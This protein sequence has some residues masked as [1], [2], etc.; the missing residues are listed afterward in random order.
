ME[1]PKNSVSAINAAKILGVAPV[2]MRLIMRRGKVKGIKIK[3]DW[4]IDL[5]SLKDY[6]N[7]NGSQNS[8]EITINGEKAIRVSRF[9]KMFNLSE[10]RTERAIVSNSLNVVKY[11]GFRYIPKSEV[12]RYK[13]RFVEHFGKKIISIE[14]A[15]LK[16]GLTIKQLSARI[17]Q[18]ELSKVRVGNKR[19]VYADELAKLLE[20]L[21]AGE[22]FLSIPQ[23]GRKRRDF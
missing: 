20:K 22:E 4:Y 10:D 18:N 12:R 8:G 13:R 15:A 11:N 3:K 5:D 14:E 21:P 16:S 9:A 6:I 23:N 2:T 7:R 17:S 1:L 19:F